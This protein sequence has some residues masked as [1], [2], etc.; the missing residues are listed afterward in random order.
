MGFS[1]KVEDRMIVSAKDIREGKTTDR[2]LAPAISAFVIK[3]QTEEEREPTL[4]QEE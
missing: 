2:Y 3:V 1:L 4:D